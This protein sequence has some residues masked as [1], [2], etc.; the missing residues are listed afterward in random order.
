MQLIYLASIYSLPD[1]NGD[2]PSLKEMKYRVKRVTEKAAEI[3][4][5]GYNVFSPL[6]HYD[7]IADYIP[8]ERMNH[9]LWL[10][11]DFDMLKRCDELWVYCLHGWERSYGI[12]QEIKY[13]RKLNMEI[14]YI[15]E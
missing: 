5:Q 10:G 14:K 3:V 8:K 7:P 11:L 9:E 4:Q 2:A 1:E 6:T 15:T 12:A 13:A